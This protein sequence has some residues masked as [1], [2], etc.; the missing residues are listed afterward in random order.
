MES[1]LAKEPCASPGGAYT[2]PIQ[3]FRERHRTTFG[4]AITLI[5]LGILSCLVGCVL[6]LVV[7][8][9]WSFNSIDTIERN[10]NYSLIYYMGLF[11][12]IGMALLMVGGLIWLIGTLHGL[13]ETT[14]FEKSTYIRG[15]GEGRDRLES[16]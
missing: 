8:R 3:T 6:W 10:L 15:A 11:T 4:A 14:Y 5:V 1:M 16:P 12:A 7:W 2:Q 9:V 13:S